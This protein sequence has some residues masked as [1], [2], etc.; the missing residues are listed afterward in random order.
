MKLNLLIRWM[1]TLIKTRKIKVKTYTKVEIATHSLISAKKL[2]EQ[3]DYISSTILAGAGREILKDICEKRGIEHTVEVVGK[4]VG[5][6]TK[7]VHDLL[8]DV[9]NKMKHADR[10]PD[11]VVEV[12]EAEPR[13]LMTVGATDLM[14]LKE[15]KSKERADLIE[16]VR[17]IKN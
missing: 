5:K 12:S 4:N 3:G 15:I 1:M 9:Y 7:D 8:A 14:K 10:D 17:S 6:T 11:E 16:F 2:Y 13:S